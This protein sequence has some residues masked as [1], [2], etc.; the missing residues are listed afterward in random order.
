MSSSLGCRTVRSPGLG[1]QF[2]SGLSIG[3]SLSSSKIM[4]PPSLR[5]T[6]CYLLSFGFALS[7]LGFLVLLCQLSINH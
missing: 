6:A 2:S 1:F 7:I 4:A 5:H 3:L